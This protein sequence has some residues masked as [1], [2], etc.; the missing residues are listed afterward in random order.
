MK[1]LSIGRL[2]SAAAILLLLGGTHTRADAILNSG[3]AFAETHGSTTTGG[4]YNNGHFQ[5]LGD[6]FPLP[7]TATQSDSYSD[8]TTAMSASSSS[9]SSVFPSP[10]GFDHLIVSGSGTG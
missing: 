10:S 5:S 9:S 4:N 6:A 7:A 1:K 3:V 8:S 2:A